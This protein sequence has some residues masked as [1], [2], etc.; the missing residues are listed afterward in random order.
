MVVRAKTSKPAATR[1]PSPSVKGRMSVEEAITRRRSVREYAAKPLSLAQLSQLLWAAQGI[2][3]QS[4]GLRAA[5]SAGALYP[6]EVCAVVKKGGVVGLDPGIYHY[7]ASD[8]SLTL[9]KSGDSS[10]KLKTAALDQDAVGLAAVNLVTTAVLQKTTV[11]YGDRGIQ[12]AFMEAGHA[13]ENVFLQAQSLGLTT[14]VVGAF[15]DEAVREV[16]GV[17]ASERPVY[18]QPVGVPVT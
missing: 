10:P 8:N 7:S 5:P 13:A 16:L 9:A 18:I 11:K 6:L 3:N 12:Y 15:D 17:G 2:T 14:V 4:D 1:L